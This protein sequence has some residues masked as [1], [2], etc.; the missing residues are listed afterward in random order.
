MKRSGR[1]GDTLYISAPGYRDRKALFELYTRNAPR[2]H[3]SFGRLAR[4]TSGF[5][6]ADIERIADRAK[7]L[8]LLHE[9]EMKNERV[10]TTGDMITVLKDKDFS[11]SSL[12]EWFSMVKKDIIS[13]TETQIVDGKKQEIIK[14][15][16]LDAQEKVIYKAL[17]RDIKKNTGATRILIKKIMRWWA[18]HVF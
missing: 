14:E 5:S 2:K 12:D 15:G 8:P 18:V 17:V 11:A 4:A 16:K 9:Y 7:M 3:I 1:F 6:P 10:L 13:K